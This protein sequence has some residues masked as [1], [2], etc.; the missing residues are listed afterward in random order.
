MP[1]V[2][3]DELEKSEDTFVEEFPPETKDPD[4]AGNAPLGDKF[5]LQNPKPIN[6]GKDLY[7]NLFIDEVPWDSAFSANDRVVARESFPDP[8]DLDMEGKRNMNATYLADQFNISFSDA[9][10]MHD[11]LAE[12]FF[13]IEDTSGGYYE[14]IKN[15]YANGVLN[16]AI[17]DKGSSLLGRFLKDPASVDLESE[18]KIIQALQKGFTQDKNEDVR[19]WHE[20]MLGATTEQLP[21]LGR[22]IK[23]GIKGGVPGGAS[24]GVSAFL[25]GQL[26]PQAA[27]PEEILTVPAGILYGLKVGSALGAGA[28]IGKLE[29]G[30][31]F[32]N[33]MSIKDENGKSI[34]PKIA[35]VVSLGVGSVNGAIEIGEWIILLSTFGIGTKVFEKAAREVTRKFL[36]EGTLSEIVTRHVLKFGGQL[37][38]ENVQELWQESVSIT[39]EELAKKLN[40]ARKGTNFKPITKEDLI[41]RLTEVTVESLRAFPALLLPGTA[42]SITKEVVG[43]AP[44]AKPTPKGIKVPTKA[45]EAVTEEK[46]ISEVFEGDGTGI[47]SEDKQQQVPQQVKESKIEEQINSIVNEPLTPEQAEEDLTKQEAAALKKLE[48]EIEIDDAEVVKPKLH[49]GNVTQRMKTKFAEIFAK[50]PEEIKGFTE[51]GFPTK[52]APIEMTKGEAKEYLGFLEEDLAKRLD[53]NLIRTENDLARANADWGDIKAVR[54]VLGEK[55]GKRP[56]TVVRAEKTKV[57]T[58]EATKKRIAAALRPGILEDSGLTVGQVLGTTLKR[59]AQAARHAFSV[60]KKQGIAV[61]KEHFR[62]LKEAQKARKALKDRIQ[63]ALKTIN[64]DVSKN[65]DFFYREAIARLQ[66]EVDT[67][68]RTKNTKRRQQTQRDFLSNATKEQKAVFPQKLFDILSAKR[69]E[70]V[71]VEELEKLAEQRQKLE[72]LGKTKKSAKKNRARLIRENNTKKAIK[73]ME[74][75][76]TSPEQD[77]AGYVANDNGLITKLKTAHITTLRMPRLLDWLDG[78]LGTFKGLMHELF[79]NRVNVQT[80]KELIEVDRR[81]KF[82]RDKMDSLGITDNE[83]STVVD[84][85]GIKSGLQLYVEQIM[86]VYA[87]LKNPRAKEALLNS[88]RISEKQAQAIVSNIARTKFVKL[89]DA[90]IEDYNDNYERLRDAHINF[91]DE[92]LGREDFYTPIVRL[93]VSGIVSSDDI[94]DQLLARSGL[95]RSQAERGFTIE[96]LN[97]A[98]ENQKPIDLRLVSIWR[99][100]SVKQEHYIHFAE[101]IKDL[102]GYLNDNKLAKAINDVLGPSGHRILNNYVKR[103]ANPNIYKGFGT[104]EMLSRKLRGN[105]AMAYL[106]YN[107]LTIAKQ[108]PSL[109]LYLKDAGASAL[110]SSFGEFVS[111]PKALLDKVAGL[112]PQIRANV[113]AREFESLERANDPTYQKLINKV[114]KTG[115]KGIIFVDRIIRTIGW[116]AVYE[117][118]LSLHGSQN[119]AIREAQNSTLRTQPT[120]SAKDLADLYTQNEVLNWFLIFTQQLNQLWNIVTY[121]VFAHWNNKNYQKSAADILAVS[122]NAMLIWMITNKRLPED[123]DD[124]LDMAT[125]QMINIVP[126]LGKDIMAGKKGWGGTDIAPLKAAKELSAA[127]SS[128]EQEKIAKALFEQLAVVTGTPVVAIKRGKEFLETGDIIELFGGEK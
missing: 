17:A 37:A 6:A 118:E 107:L 94:T 11:Q 114:G 55:I 39:G 27:I 110:L 9:L 87:A 47:P 62:K 14:R 1:E 5:A 38:V 120:A 90:V 95:K 57:F 88:L 105:M 33:L 84:L 127:I 63:K 2:F 20:K 85:S 69:L 128:G 65:V 73:T 40:N 106:S 12:E 123:E 75:V 92:D 66:K 74:N 28:E 10:T 46:V 70:D 121:D 34:D 7:K 30:N 58:I 36:V 80:N 19:S 96:R 111:N 126:L 103:V 45:A 21:V 53:E 108:A 4:F 115:L 119:E 98:P 49:I 99:G 83:L 44:V 18:L 23:G 113:I 29:A 100:Q 22:G 67:K 64:K 82:M 24:G 51:E 89:A 77:G 86:G 56:F 93:E 124:F 117:K 125:D 61:T 54:E 13:N 31:T 101:L 50:Q 3:L 59:M 32:A 25:L 72:Q 15:R 122:L 48:A 60:G 71:T 35:V 102:N 26:G 97:I 104:M 8:K 41:A 112:D 78:K 116:N 76:K 81:H 43:A 42:V 68:K 109:V 16:N 52:K 91:T 79:Y